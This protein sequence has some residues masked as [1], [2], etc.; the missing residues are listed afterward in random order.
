MAGNPCNIATGNKYQREVDRAGGIGQLPIMRHYNSLRDDVDVGF[1]RGWTA[2]F[3]TTL[4]AVGN[5]FRV[6]RADGRAY[7]FTNDGGSWHADPDVQT[8]LFDDGQGYLVI[9]ADETE[10]RYDGSGRLLSETD[11]NGR[12][13]S[14]SYDIAGRL[15]GIAGPLGATL[16]LSYDGNG[17]VISISDDAGRQWTYRYDDDDNLQFVDNPDGSTRQYHYDDG[18]IIIF[19]MKL[20]KPNGLNVFFH[21]V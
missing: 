4:E 13:R 21:T 12:T 10:Q 8:R 15:T 20:P 14:F 3:L 17:H 7:R 2:G 18:Q 1:G 9:T 5:D 19:T 6:R 16:S 11:R